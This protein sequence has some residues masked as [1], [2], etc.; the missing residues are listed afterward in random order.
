MRQLNYTTCNTGVAFSNGF[1][2][3]FGFSF[4]LQKKITFSVEKAHLSACCTPT[5]T[6]GKLFYSGNDSYSQGGGGLLQFVSYSSRSC[7]VSPL[8]LSAWNQEDQRV[9]VPAVFCL[10]R[11]TRKGETTPLR[12]PFRIW[13]PQDL[14]FIWPITPL[15]YYPPPREVNQGIAWLGVL[16]A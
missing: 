6:F 2:T 3:G 10:V 9:K 16:W 14:T 15:N 12:I 7:L 11:E 8:S 4:L 13:I 5:D 1:T